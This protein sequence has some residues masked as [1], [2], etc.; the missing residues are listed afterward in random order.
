MTTFL[1]ITAAALYLGIGYFVS[2]VFL[3]TLA[4]VLLID[5]TSL[6]AG[7][8]KLVTYGGIVISMLLWPLALLFVLMYSFYKKISKS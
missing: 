4:S 6:D 2:L 5:G 1:Y 8:S 3:I 7:T